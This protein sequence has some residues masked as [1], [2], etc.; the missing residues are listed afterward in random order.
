M[1]F[2]YTDD[3]SSS[4]RFAREKFRA[5]ARAAGAELAS[6]V[7]PDGQGIDGE[8]LTIDVCRLGN[9]R[10]SRQFLMIS[11]T[12]GMEGYAGSALQVAWL[13]S[14]LDPALLTNIGVVLVHGLNPYGFSHGIRTTGA[15]VDL[16]RNFIDHDAVAPTNLRYEEVHSHL[17]ADVSDPNEWQRAEQG[18]VAVLDRLGEDALFDAVARGQYTHP[19]GVFYGGTQRTWENLALERILVEFMG[20]AE[21]VAA[22]DWHTGIGSYG[23]PF[24]LAFSEQG[25]QALRETARWWGEEHVLAAQPHG[26]SRPRYQGLVFDGVRTFLPRAEVAGGVIEWG[27]RGAEAG[28]IAIRQDLWLR[29]HA[30]RLPAD[31]LTQLRA[32]LLDSLNPVSYLWRTSVLSEGIRVMEATANGLSRW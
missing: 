17:V 30:A 29:Q 18:L 13:R 20:H 1:F 5:A 14:R 4:Y 3:F 2:R 28:D 7:H 24:F 11:G 9:P 25:S 31:T 26:R 22:I 6:H 27:T 8:D 16:N 10:S 15:G 32:D 21:K 19:D 23:K 12:H